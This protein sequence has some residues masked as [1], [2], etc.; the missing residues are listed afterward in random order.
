MN[1]GGADVDV[2]G[3]N[4]RGDKPEWQHSQDYRAERDELPATDLDD[5]AFVYE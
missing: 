5:P 3:S 2:R 4:A 1:R